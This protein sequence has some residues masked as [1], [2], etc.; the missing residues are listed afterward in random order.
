MSVNSFSFR[1]TS[2]P[3]PPKS[4]YFLVLSVVIFVCVLC[5]T[6][7]RREEVCQGGRLRLTCEQGAVIQLVSVL[8]VDSKCFGSSNCC[9]RHDDCSTTASTTHQTTAR[10]ICNGQTTCSLAT[11]KRKIP[12]GTFGFPVYNDY[13][14]ITYRCIGEN[15]HCS[16]IKHCL[17][18][19][20]PKL[21]YTA[22]F[23]INS[24]KIYTLTSFIVP[25]H[26]Q[27]E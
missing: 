17:I 11:E 15:A 19:M 6:A 7:E 9:P 8:L 5:V 22:V 12:C 14:R 27:G 24:Y 25:Q 18:S 4:K 1:G 21:T 2:P 13:E 3:L 16:V 10:N 20:I 26:A 23:I